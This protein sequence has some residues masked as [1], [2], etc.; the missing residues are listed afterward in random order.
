MSDQW[1]VA[2]NKQRIGP[3]SSAQLRQMASSGQL[4]PTEMVLQ[5]GETKWCA[6]GAL[7]GL[8]PRES[9][10]TLDAPNDPELPINAHLYRPDILTCIHLALDAGER[11]LALCNFV[12]I[13]SQAKTT[14]VITDRH[15]RL[16]GF[17]ESWLGGFTNPAEIVANRAVSVRAITGISTAELGILSYTQL[18][19]FT[20]KLQLVFWWDGHQEVLVTTRVPEGKK[21]ANKLSEAVAARDGL[22]QG[23]SSLADELKKL[24]QLIADGI[25]SAEEFGKAKQQLIGLSPSQV[26][27]ATKLLRHL[28]ALRMQGVLTDGEFNMKKWDIL[29]QRLI[30][31]P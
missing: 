28:H 1:Y 22:R 2:R 20:S 15:V 13:P 8:F 26:D 27:E 30:P 6:A 14:L 19:F 11:A 4:M 12:V 7:Q 16:V 17:R 18:G 31:R 10:A 9:V 5:R 29:S 24:A 21:F 23:P 25:L 3:F